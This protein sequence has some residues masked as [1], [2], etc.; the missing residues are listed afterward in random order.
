MQWDYMS[1]IPDRHDGMVTLRAELRRLKDCWHCGGRCGGIHWPQEWCERED[2][3]LK[4]KLCLGC[5]ATLN[6]GLELVSAGEADH[7]LGS[8][9]EIRRPLKFCQANLGYKNCKRF[10]LKSEIMAAVE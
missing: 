5:F 10:Y 1:L 2:I 4:R 7:T 6:P 3:K 9:R 8:T